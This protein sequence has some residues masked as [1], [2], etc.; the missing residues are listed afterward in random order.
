LDPNGWKGRNGSVGEWPR[1]EVGDPKDFVF[2]VN[3]TSHAEMDTWRK[4][5][6]EW[7]NAHAAD[8]YGR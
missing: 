2:E 7:I 4:E 3:R 6:M 1:Y 5:G 8:V